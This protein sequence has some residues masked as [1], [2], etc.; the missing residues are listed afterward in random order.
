MADKRRKGL[1]IIAMVVAGAA[2]IWSVWYFV[3]SR[4]HVTTDN[5]YVIGNV[6]QITPQVAGTVVSIEADE[7]DFVKAGQPL[8][9]LDKADAKVALEQAQ[10]QLAQTVREVRS[11]FACLFQT[12]NA[13]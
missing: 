8:V 3:F 13:C 12:A 5:A 10:S 6:L 4:H 7:T 9:K 11:L 2:L 1:Q